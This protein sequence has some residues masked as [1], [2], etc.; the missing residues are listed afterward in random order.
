M[1]IVIPTIGT[2]GDV[3]PYLALA[4]GLSAAGHSVTVMTH[5]ALGA[6][7]SA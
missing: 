3:Q 5:P 6:L 1:R 4:A 7:V 2:R